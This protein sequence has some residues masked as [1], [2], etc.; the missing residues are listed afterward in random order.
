[1]IEA[2]EEDLSDSIWA[3]T[4]IEASKSPLKFKIGAAIIDK[5]N[6]LVAVGHNSTKT[7]PKYGSKSPWNTMHA[8][9][10]ALY[11]CKKLGID[12]KGMT[13]IIYR[14]GGLCKPCPDCQKLIEKA[15]INKVIYTW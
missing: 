7:H 6:R 10:A 5:K 15:K 8:E 1:M 12:P 14:R 13:M 2:T 11:N 4:S 3:L 9:G